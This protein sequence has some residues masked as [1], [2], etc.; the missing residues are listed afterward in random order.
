MVAKLTR[1]AHKIAIQ[2][3]LVVQ[4]CTICGS[5]LLA[6][7]SETFGYNLVLFFSILSKNLFYVYTNL[8]FIF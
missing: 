4:S 3:H 8:S 2:L 7:S 1:L 5:L 6:T